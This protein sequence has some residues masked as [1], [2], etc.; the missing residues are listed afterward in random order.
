MGDVVQALPV[1]RLI[2][3]HLPR[4]EVYWWL[5]SGLLPLLQGDPHLAGIFTFDRDRWKSPWNWN[6]VL[7]SIHEMRSCRFDWVIDLQGLARSGLFAWLANGQFTIGV[8]DPREGAVGF[9]DVFV[10]RPS[11]HTHAVD[12]YLQLLPILGV[13]VHW[14]FTWLPPQIEASR[15]QNW[16][17]TRSGNGSPGTGKGPFWTGEM[18]F[19][20]VAIVR[21][22]QF[23]IVLVIYPLLTRAGTRRSGF[24][25]HFLFCV[26]E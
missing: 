10:P 25:T 1:L 3:S 22:L 21:A 12:W 15:I 7:R 2:K 11:F 24:R 26:K 23:L 13:P 18:P 9:Y 4:S 8:N 16:P 6:E 14:N 20:Q 5:A 19:G 17:G